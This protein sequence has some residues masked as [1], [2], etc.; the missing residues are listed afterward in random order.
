MTEV[1]ENVKML[2]NM[3]TPEWLC[4]VLAIQFLIS[5]RSSA[6]KKRNVSGRSLSNSRISRFETLEERQL[7]SVAPWDAGAVA[8]EA[9]VVDA[10]DRKSVV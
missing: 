7:L 9:S 3:V 6:M 4:E 10:P 5:G 8:M 2:G 1:V